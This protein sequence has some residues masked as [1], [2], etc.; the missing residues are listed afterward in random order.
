LQSQ[1][2]ERAIKAEQLKTS[3]ADKAASLAS[4]EEQLQ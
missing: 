3:L 4:T 1:A 2:E